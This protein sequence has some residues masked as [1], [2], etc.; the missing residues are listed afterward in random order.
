MKYKYDD[1]NEIVVDSFAGG[2]TSTGDRISH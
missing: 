1:N 2:G